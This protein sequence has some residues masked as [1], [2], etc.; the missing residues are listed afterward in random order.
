MRMQYDGAAAPARDSETPCRGGGAA[1]RARARSLAALLA[2]LGSLVPMLAGADGAPA[3]HLVPGLIVVTVD[4]YATNS[5]EMLLTLDQADSAGESWTIGSELS[6]ADRS[7]HHSGYG[8]KRINR[9]EDLAT[10]HHI[11]TRFHSDEEAQVGATNFAVSREVFDEIRSKGASSIDVV[12]IPPGKGDVYDPNLPHERKNFRGTLNRVGRETMRVLVDGVPAML[13]VL[14][15]KGTLKAR[16]MVRDFEFWWLDDPDVRLQL[17]WREED[18]SE[19]VV[20]RINH[21]RPPGAQDADLQRQL[22]GKTC[23]AEATG[24]YFATG[25]ADLLAASRPALASMAGVLKAHP[26]WSVTI[27]G[28]TD[29]VG[30]DAKNLAL[31]RARAAAVKA[32]LTQRLGIDAA[33]VKADGFGSKRPVDTNATPDGRARNRRV[34]VSRA[35]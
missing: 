13:P 4:V 27:E 16:E 12:E 20:V 25:S 22:A 23:R 15:A 33:R 2:G 18:Y 19:D 8:A 3:V 29:N 34:E 31:S 7:S 28:H 26:D 11:F 1:R 9:A 10:S 35:C 6:A 24:V 32:E 5:P 30:D 21:P 14:H 17:R